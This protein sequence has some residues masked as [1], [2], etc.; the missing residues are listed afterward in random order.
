MWVSAV[1]ALAKQTL[2][3]RSGFGRC[4]QVIIRELRHNT[5]FFVV[6]GSKPVSGFL[7]GKKT[8]VAICSSG[9]TRIGTVCS[10]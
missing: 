9:Q 3:Y 1:V 4:E 2:R 8:A 6:F 7:H 10:F 5:I